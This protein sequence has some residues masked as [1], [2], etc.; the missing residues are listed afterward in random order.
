M[1][2]CDRELSPQFV[3]N[4]RSWT[5][6]TTLGGVGL[7]GVIFVIIDLPFDFDKIGTKQIS[8]GIYHERMEA[9]KYITGARSL[10]YAFRSVKWHEGNFNSGVG[11]VRFTHYGIHLFQENDRAVLYLPHEMQD[12]IERMFLLTAILQTEIHRQDVHMLSALYLG[13]TY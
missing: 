10:W 3:S 1:P 5:V 7:L 13:V 9:G 11:I 12:E 8:L 2:V 4:C 6:H